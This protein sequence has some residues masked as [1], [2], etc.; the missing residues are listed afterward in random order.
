MLESVTFPRGGDN[1][2][3]KLWK[4]T[5][6]FD[7]VT[8]ASGGPD[9]IRGG[10]IKRHNIRFLICHINAKTQMCLDSQTRVSE[11]C[12]FVCLRQLWLVVR[13]VRQQRHLSVAAEYGGDPIECWDLLALGY[14]KATG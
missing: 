12:G 1:D 7:R 9:G 6:N 3:I 14:F 2:K 10:V 11:C 4:R 5:R 13:K 8:F